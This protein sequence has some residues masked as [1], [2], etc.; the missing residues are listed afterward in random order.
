M[1]ARKR[2]GKLLAR[3]LPILVWLAAVG[4]VVLLFGQRHRSFQLAGLAV[5]PP[6]TL[7]AADNGIVRLIPVDLFQSVQSGDLLAIVELG[8]PPQN[9]YVRALTAARKATAT[10]EL[11]RL[12]A[13]L[14]AAKKQIVYDLGL[15]AGDEAL[16]YARLALAADNAH[17][18]L[19]NIRTDLELDR[20]LLAGLKLERDALRQLVEREAVY[21]YEVRQAELEYD[22]LAAKIAAAE[23][24]KQQAQRNLDEAR[25]RTTAFSQAAR[26]TA[27][28]DTLIDPHRKTLAVQ[29][30]Q[31]EEYFSPTG[32]MMLT[33]RFDGVITQITASEGQGLQAGDPIL[34]LSPPA[35]DYILA[36]LDPVR[37]GGV[38]ANQP[39][40]ISKHSAP[41]QI[42]RSEITVVG[43]AVEMLPEQLW[44]NPT[45]P[46]W[47]RPIKIRIPSEIQLAGNEV[48]GIRGL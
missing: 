14:N 45:N 27:L 23:T 8:S 31:I 6:Q 34:T 40:E 19:L 18:E 28:I 13:E 9:D 38:A 7:S 41:Q 11:Q 25:K 21:D 20:G 10:A 36:W 15:D 35:A 42:F 47:G 2:Q 39:V 33:A 26:D 32:R 12:E 5:A 44:V 30:R 4:G 48:V 3:M 29:E 16:T 1:M 46:Q 37:A 24:Q 43:P 17:L 22:A